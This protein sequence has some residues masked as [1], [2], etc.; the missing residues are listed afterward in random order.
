MTTTTQTAVEFLLAK[1]NSGKNFTADRWQT[2]CD[3]A[4]AM[5]NAQLDRAKTDGYNL[6][7]GF[8]R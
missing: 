7:K 4:K 2:I 3:L 5:E 8:K 6:A 1:V